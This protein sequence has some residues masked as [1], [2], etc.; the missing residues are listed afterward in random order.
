M[1]YLCKPRRWHGLQL[2]MH[3][4]LNDRGATQYYLHT[5]DI[6]DDVIITVF[7]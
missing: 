4:I 1:S 5:D 3:S 2:E 6:F 7:Y